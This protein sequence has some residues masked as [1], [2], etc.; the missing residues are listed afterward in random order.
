MPF[1]DAVAVDFRSRLYLTAVCLQLAAFEVGCLTG[2]KT[3]SA[4]PRAASKQ[5][6]QHMEG[7]ALLT[8]EARAM[9]GRTVLA[10]VLGVTSLAF[11]QLLRRM[12]A[13]A[14]FLERD[15]VSILV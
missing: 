15:H 14:T 8:T 3:C 11:H 13:F 4:F 9:S 1:R 5:K 7:T 2:Q 6:L 12:R 10:A